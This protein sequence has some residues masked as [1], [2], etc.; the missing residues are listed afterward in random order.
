MSLWLAKLCGLPA[1]GT[2]HLLRLSFV[3]RGADLR[4]S[5]LKIDSLFG[6]K[7]HSMISRH[8]H[9]T[10]AVLIAAADAV[11]NGPIKLMASDQAQP[12]L[13]GSTGMILQA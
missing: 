5:E 1:C 9:S 3:S 11:A 2:P 8:G 13:R 7:T 12:L 10:D 4:Y 6:R